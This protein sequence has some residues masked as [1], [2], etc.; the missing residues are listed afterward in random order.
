MLKFSD[1]R[2]L[3]ILES[4]QDTDLLEKLKP[5]DPTSK[6]I[7][8]FVHSDNP[9]FAGKSKKERIR[10]A[11]G[12][13][14]AVMRKM[15]EEAEQLDELSPS[16]LTSYRHKARNSELR[17]AE[18]ARRDT[19]ISQQTTNP[20]VAAK[21]AAY[22]AQA[23]ATVQKRRAGQL[24]ATSR[25]SNEEAEQIKEAP[26]TDTKYSVEKI[27]RHPDGAHT[28]KIKYTHPNGKTG[29]HIHSGK[30]AYVAKLVKD[31]YNLSV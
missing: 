26:K 27:H 31:R 1:L 20:R 7:S 10:M 5:S 4:I 21:S 18:T 6:Y 9:K 24:K 8:D 14:Y 23:Q 15:K 11:L 2:L 19:E 16:T 29:H 17:S 3:Q 30:P 28:V 22:A 13:K 12:A 25:L